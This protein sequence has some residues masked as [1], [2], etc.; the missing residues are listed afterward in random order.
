MFPSKTKSLPT[1]IDHLKNTLAY[2]AMTRTKKKLLIT[3]PLGLSFVGSYP[4]FSWGQCY[5]PFYGRNLRIFVRRKSVCPWQA[6]SAYYN[7]H[8]SLMRKYVNYSR[9]KFYNIRPWSFLHPV[10][11]SD[12]PSWDPCSPQLP[13]YVQSVGVRTKIFRGCA[14]REEGSTEIHRIV[15]S[16]LE[17]SFPLPEN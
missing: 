4:W 7:K 5:K 17:W 9:K 11:A 16:S 1:K 3:L 6:F 14:F 2:L 15:R 10:A 12:P 13:T 8:S